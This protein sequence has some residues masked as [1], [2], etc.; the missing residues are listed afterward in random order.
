MKFCFACKKL[1]PTGDR[2]NRIDFASKFVYNTPEYRQFQLEVKEAFLESDLAKELLSP[3]EGDCEF[4]YYVCGRPNCDVDNY[5]K[6][7]LDSI[8]RACIIKNDSQIQ[9]L[10]GQ[11]CQKCRDKKRGERCLY[12]FW[13]ELRQISS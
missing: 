2:R 13:C 4:D 5:A 11:K 8:Q 12:S 7:M 9:K 6:S 1:P 10:V 3:F